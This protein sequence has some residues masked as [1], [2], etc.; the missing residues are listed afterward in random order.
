MTKKKPV[1]EVEEVEDNEVEAVE[2]V[3]VIKKASSKTV[4]PVGITYTYVGG[5]EASPHVINFMGKQRFVRGEPV[6]ITDPILLQKLAN[7]PCFVDG[8]ID[9]KQLHEYDAEEAEKAAEQRKKDEKLN[10][11][12]TK[13][14]K[15]EK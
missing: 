14:F 13:K 8:E 11:S 7:H 5:G 3:Q 6:E 4:K 10:A 2:E 15:G 9:P 12:W 1:K